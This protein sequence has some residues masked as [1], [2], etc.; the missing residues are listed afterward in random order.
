MEDA[1]KKNIKYLDPT[2]ILWRSS[3]QWIG[4]LF[5]LFILIIIFSNKSFNYKMTNL[6]FS[7]DSNFKSEENIK[8]NILKIFF[9]YS[10]LS[11]IILI[12][13]S[14]SGLR[15]FNSL[16]M[17]MTLVSGGGFLPTDSINKIISTNFQKIIFIFSLIL[18][19]LNFYLLLNLFN[20][21]ILI[22]EGSFVAKIFLGTSFNEIIA[23]AKTI[24][25]DVK[26]FKPK[27]SRKES[28]ESFIICKIL[29]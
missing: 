2:L 5:F 24:F 10:A 14:F 18:S 8:N 22:K 20:K 17:S 27:S 19:M 9:I 6:T 23:L 7:G 4:G 15:L 3:S 29:R 13:L 26:V 11:I 16:N 21:N 1:L 12:L 25:K 28:K